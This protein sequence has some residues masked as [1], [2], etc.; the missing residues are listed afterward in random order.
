MFLL[1]PLGWKGTL[2]NLDILSCSKDSSS[3]VTDH[4]VSSI[5]FSPEYFYMV[6]TKTNTS[7]ESHSILLFKMGFNFVVFE[8]NVTSF[9]GVS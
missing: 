7:E 4:K 8:L 1:F 9:V 6:H 3:Y 5:F 2:I